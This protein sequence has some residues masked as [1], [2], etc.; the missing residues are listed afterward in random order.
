[1]FKL[2]FGNLTDFSAVKKILKIGSELMQLL[3][4]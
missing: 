2:F 4:K 1:M 3:S